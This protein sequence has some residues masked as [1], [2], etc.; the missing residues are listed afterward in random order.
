MKKLIAAVL[1]GAV[2][3]AAGA[4]EPDYS[5]RDRSLSDSVRVDAVLRQL[6]LAE[7]VGLLGTTV[8]VERLGIGDYC[9]VEGLHGLSLGSPGARHPE[10]NRPTTIFPQ[11]YGLGESWDTTLV[12]R[13][14]EQASTE[15][16]YYAQRPGAV[17]HALVMLAP[18]ADLARDPRW[19]RTE[20]SF[21]ED[22]RLAA[23]MTVAPCAA[24]RVTTA[25]TG[26]WRR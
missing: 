17:R 5:F 8:G 21:G 11:A 13:V 3:C 20:E 7:K 6:T 9:I 2:M 26:A 15:A 23:A 14:A 10:N 18:N 24:S 16:R 4:H 12:R 19:G 25:A 22:P 1:A